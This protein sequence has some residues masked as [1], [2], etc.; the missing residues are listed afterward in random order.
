MSDPERSGDG[1]VRTFL[2]E[3]DPTVFGIGFVV[4]VVIVAAFL[5]RENRTLDLMEGTNEFLWT[6]LGWAYLVS[7]F[8]LVGFVLYL[9]FGPW[10]NIKLGEEDEDPEFSFLA[11]FAMLY[12]AGIAAGIVFWG[13]RRR[14]TTTRRPRRFRASKRSRRPPPSARSSTRSSTGGSRRGRRT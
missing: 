5:F 2:D 14:F 9:V 6:N 8:V 7:M 1:A 12:S 3:L 10:G 11:Y 13:Q 4:A